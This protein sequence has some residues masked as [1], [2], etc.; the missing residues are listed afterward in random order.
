MSQRRERGGLRRA[1]SL[2]LAVVMLV[3]LAQSAIVSA[4]DPSDST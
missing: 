4:G 3:T 2:L 1:V